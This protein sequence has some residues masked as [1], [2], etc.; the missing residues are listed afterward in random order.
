MRQWHIICFALGQERKLLE[1]LFGKEKRPPS[2]VP[3]IQSTHAILLLHDKYI[4][5]LRD[6][7]ATIA[8]PGQWSLFGGLKNFEERPLD[9]IK[10]EI[11]EELVIE[12]VRF[13]FLWYV[14]YFSSFE[15]E[16]IGTWFFVSDVTAV[17]HE[18]K[19]QEGQAARAFAFEQI[20]YLEMPPVMRQ[21]IGKFQRRAKSS[22]QN[23]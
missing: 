23:P 13:R 17:W 18:H 10:R 11:Y 19:L 3:E 4:L 22:E 2:K 6:D 7:K 15:G 20:P 8:A 14:V 16:A 1:M 9:A 5:Q 21:T 12:P